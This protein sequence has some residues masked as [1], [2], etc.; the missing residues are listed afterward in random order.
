MTFP[1]LEV[2]SPKDD[3]KPSH[4]LEERIRSYA[5]YFTLIRHQHE[6]LDREDIG[7]VI[8]LA[9][10]RERLEQK[11]PAPTDLGGSDDPVVQ[12]L[13]S[14]LRARMAEGLREHES[15]VERMK[16][17]RSELAAEIGEVEVR[18]GA[19]QAYI[20]EDGPTNVTRV[21]LKF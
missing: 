3:D 2:D 9:E 17:V 15:L 16:S 11:L 18:T 14:R 1:R 12:R 13:V 21:D 7:E 10:E 19:L 20:R 8:S 6:A 5:R 4:D